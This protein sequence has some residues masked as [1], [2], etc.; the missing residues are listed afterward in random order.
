LIVLDLRELA[1]LD[2]D[3]LPFKQNGPLDV[4]YES[5]LGGNDVLAVCRS[6]KRGSD[7]DRKVSVSH[8]SPFG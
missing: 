7:Y 4:L 3:W 6:R 8:D 1:V 2:F 5:R